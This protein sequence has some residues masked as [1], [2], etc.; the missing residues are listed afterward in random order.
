MA[1]KFFT[2]KAPNPYHWILTSCSGVFRNVWV[3]LAPFRYCV[4]LIANMA[5]LVQLMQMFVQESRF[6]IFR[7]E[8]SRSI[9]M[10]PNVMFLCV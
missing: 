10:D 8:G 4:K 3:P 9:P 2:M 6:G 5:E 7:N 1:S